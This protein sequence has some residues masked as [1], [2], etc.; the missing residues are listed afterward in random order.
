LLA[1][2]DRNET[3][4]S[5]TLKGMNSLRRRIH[6]TVGGLAWPSMATFLTRPDRSQVSKKV[7]VTKTAVNI[8]ARRPSV[9][10]TAKPLIAPVPYM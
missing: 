4:T 3:T 2:N 5:A 7:R 8:E 10:V 6:P 9:S 1:T